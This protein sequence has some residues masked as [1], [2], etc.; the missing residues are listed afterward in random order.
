MKT[1]RS[2]SVGRGLLL[3]RQ[4]GVVAR[5]CR[6][7]QLLTGASDSTFSA[8]GADRELSLRCQQSALL[9]ARNRPG[10]KDAVPALHCTQRLRSPAA[11]R[12]VSIAP[13]RTAAEPVAELA[14]RE[15]LVWPSQ[16]LAECHQS[17]VRSIQSHCT[18]PGEE[19]LSRSRGGNLGFRVSFRNPQPKWERGRLGFFPRPPLS[20]PLVFGY[21]NFRNKRMWWVGCFNTPFI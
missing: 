17:S 7:S 15:F 11:G 9:A 20:S 18:R 16:P 4:K 14:A 19:R 10:P 6:A 5:S 13:A 21:D 3:L 2:Q 1:G 12:S 8:A